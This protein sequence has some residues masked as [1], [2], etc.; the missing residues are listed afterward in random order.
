MSELAMFNRSAVAEWASA[1]DCALA[2]YL[3]R[4]LATI[5]GD[6]GT[7]DARRIFEQ[8]IAAVDYTCRN[9]LNIYRWDSRDEITVTIKYGEIILDH[10]DRGRDG[11]RS[12]YHE[13]RTSCIVEP[14]RLWLFVKGAVLDELLCNMTISTEADDG[15]IDGFKEVQKEI[16]DTII[17]YSTSVGR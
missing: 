14:D 5:V 7:I 13:Y 3:P 4:V 10:A 12:Y 15:A 1:I 9:C 2:P 6:Y 8:M 17:R 16:R 11:N